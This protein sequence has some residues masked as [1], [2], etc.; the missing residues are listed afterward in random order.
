VSSNSLATGDWT[1]R[2]IAGP[3]PGDA[4][5]LFCFPHA[6]GGASLFRSWRT[7]LA[8]D[9]EVCPVQLP[10]REDRWRE[11]PL[12]DL[13]ALVP[14]ICEGLGN[15]FDT[16][17]AFFG[18]SMGAFI[19]FELARHLR[20]THRSGPAIVVV[21][22]AR[23][24]QLPD[25][26]PQA[27]RLPAAELLRELQRFDGIPT[28]LLEHEEL[29]ALLLRTLRADLELCETYAYLDE[30]PLDCA[31]SAYGGQHD[32]KVPTAQLPPWQAQTT[33][34]FHLRIFPG[35]HFFFLQEARTAV[36]QAL[37]DDLSRYVQLSAAAALVAPQARVERLIADLWGELLRVPKV[38]LDDNF[39]DLGGNS[40][41]MVQAHHRLRQQL[42]TSLSV[43][44][45]FRY[46]TIR[47]LANAI[48][49]LRSAA[50]DGMPGRS[51]KESHRG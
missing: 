46:P 44:D 38:G 23:A 9:I 40:L 22:G 6:G 4:V 7:A 35:N 1:R 16:P 17:F 33:G 28:E 50:G 18:H 25:P 39:F 11:A 13:R 48:E 49:P 15:A 45:L 42:T 27:H 34:D 20:R 41:L 12:T 2:M 32:E 29:T 10:G 30:P 36:L 8:P 31:I 51:E 37:R 3:Q 19:A 24:P 21:S 14:S 47:L 5:R 43:V 26:D